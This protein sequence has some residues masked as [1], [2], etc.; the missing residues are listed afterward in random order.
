M[1]LHRHPLGGRNFE[2]FS[3]DPFLAGR[4][5]GLYIKGL[6]QRGVGAS[7]KHFAAN[8][9]ETERFNIDVNVS[10]KALRYVAPLLRCFASKQEL[11]LSIGKF[12]SSRSKLPSKKVS[13]GLS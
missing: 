3:E 1:C 6:Q 11:T 13:H 10:Q 5:A 2:A 9:Q 12:T 4:L 7:I 8:E